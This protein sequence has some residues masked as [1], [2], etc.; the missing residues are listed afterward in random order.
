V[1]HLNEHHVESFKREDSTD[2][3][4]T[5]LQKVFLPCFYQLVCSTAGGDRDAV[6]QVRSCWCEVLSIDHPGLLMSFFIIYTSVQVIILQF[7][8]EISG[9]I[10]TVMTVIN[11]QKEK[12]YA[13][14][15]CPKNGQTVHCK[16]GCGMGAKGHEEEVRTAK[17]EL[18]KDSQQ[19][20][21]Q[22]G[23]Y[24]EDQ[25]HFQRTGRRGGAVLPDMTR[26]RT[27]VLGKV[28]TEIILTSYS[29]Q[30]HVRI[31]LS[32]S[33]VICHCYSCQHYY[34]TDAFSQ[35]TSR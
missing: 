7:L 1:Q 5:E 19:R 28:V 25:T 4:F 14:C 26:G 27:K 18:R 31:S 10:I 16:T 9:I 35:E 32:F 2:Q 29:K 23:L 11:Y 8:S 17:D 34:N 12:A 15:V 3:L 21:E 30:N 20:P 24:G 22:T 13:V 33:L 6:D